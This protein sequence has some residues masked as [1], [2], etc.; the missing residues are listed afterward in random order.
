GGDACRP[1]ADGEV[2]V[3]AGDLQALGQQGLEA[4]EIADLG[5]LAEEREGGLRVLFQ[6]GQL[7]AEGLLRVLE[8]ELVDARGGV[9]ELTRRGGEL[10]VVLVVHGNL[11]GGQ[12]PARMAGLCDAAYPRDCC[13]ATFPDERHRN[14]SPS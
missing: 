13:D 12:V 14:R 8:G 3:L 4:V 11:L 2:D 1:G 6:R 5:S 9:G 7:Q 10:L